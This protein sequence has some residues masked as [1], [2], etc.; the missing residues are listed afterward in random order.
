MKN[1]T[2]ILEHPQQSV[3]C[4]S[5]GALGVVTRSRAVHPGRTALLGTVLATSALSLVVTEV[6]GSTSWGWLGGRLRSPARVLA[7]GLQGK[8]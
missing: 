5:A 3:L 7:P 6:G 2:V 8:G 4:P 1:Q